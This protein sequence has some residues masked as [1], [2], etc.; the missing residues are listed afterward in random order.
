MNSFSI[1]G[2][3]S[4]GYDDVGRDISRCVKEDTEASVRCF[5]SGA[6]KR[7][8]NSTGAAKNDG[9]VYCG[10]W[11]QYVR[12]DLC[13]REKI[14]KQ[15]DRSLILIHVQEIFKKELE[16]NKACKEKWWELFVTHF[17]RQA[18]AS[19]QNKMT[20]WRESEGLTGT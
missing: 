12:E 1:G 18:N 11:K 16:K 13:V 7:K 19:Q 14:G 8:V 10:A 6:W 9:Y 2:K 4:D 17:R 20:I 5:R 15:A 3:D